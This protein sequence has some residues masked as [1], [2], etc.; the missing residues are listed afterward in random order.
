AAGDVDLPRERV[1][2]IDVAVQHQGDR[3][4]EV[5]DADAALLAGEA[6][7]VAERQVDGAA[8]RTGRGRAQERQEPVG[9][10]PDVAAHPGAARH[11]ALELAGGRA[12]TAQGNAV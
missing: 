8:H 3:I 1:V 7:Q 9:A 12:R 2:V 6:H 5:A 10:R 4:Q 11:R